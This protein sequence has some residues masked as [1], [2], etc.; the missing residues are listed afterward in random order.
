MTKEARPKPALYERLGKYFL[1]ASVAAVIVY[2]PNFGI[3][4][5][6]TLPISIGLGGVLWLAGI[7]IGRLIR[8]RGSSESAGSVQSTDV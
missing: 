3:P 4:L 2:G 5:L 1:S 8:R 7:G 6:L